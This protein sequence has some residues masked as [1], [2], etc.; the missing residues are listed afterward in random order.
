MVQIIQDLVEFI[1]DSPSPW[2]AVEQIGNR[3]THHKFRSLSEEERWDL[4]QGET[5]FVEKGGSLIAFRIPKEPIQKTIILASH[6]DSPCLKIKPHAEFRSH[7]MNLFRIETYG[8][9]TLSTWF[10]RDLALTG[11]VFASNGKEVKKHLIYAK[12]HLVTIPSLAIHLQEK[13]DG[14]PKQYIDKQEHLC[15]LIG[16]SDKKQ[17]SLEKLLKSEI[18]DLDLLSHDLY[19]VPTQPPSF[20][21]EKKELISSYRLDNLSSVHASL[22]ALLSSKKNPKGILQIC[23]FWNNEEI[24]SQTNEGAMSSFLEDVLKRIAFCL[25]IGQEDYFRMKSK[26]LCLSIDVAHCFHPN[27]AKRYDSEDHPLFEEGPMIK[28]NANMRYAT[29]ADSAAKIAFICKKNKIPYQIS[30]G[31]SEITGGSTV[32][33]HVSSSTGIA[34]IDIGPPLLGMHSTR[35][36]MATKDHLTLCKL[37]QA[38]LEEF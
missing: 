20:I 32:G 6:T 21:G 25:D 31:H 26:S 24:G 12:D 10:D 11:Q 7:N 5:Y 29:T 23:V 17:D 13:H 2:H 28:Y 4:K 22:T 3:L 8:G 18:K 15:P 37:L 19:L 1:Q 27:F 16:L 14:K 9:P 30:S 33:P 36:L 38:C 35:E 34:T